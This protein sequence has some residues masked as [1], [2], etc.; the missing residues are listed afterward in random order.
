[1]CN[2][3]K[4]NMSDVAS[5][6]SWRLRQAATSDANGVHGLACEPLVYQYLFD[7]VAP[8][9]K[10]IA[11]W[12]EQSIADVAEV[13]V[14]LWVLESH[15]VGYAGCVQ[16]RPDLSSR[17]AELTYFLDPANRGQGLA[18]RMG[19]TA[20]TQAFLSPKLDFVFAGADLPNI[21]SF[22]VMRR[23]GM[24]FRQHVR[25][26]LGAGVEYVRHRNDTGPMPRPKLLLVC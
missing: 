26:P 19:W 3:R 10:W 23:L 20:V 1:M 6:D 5:Q 14:G 9:R 11:E 12:I 21:A 8:D 15:A 16:L 17:S 22:D 7:G 25:Y 24:R 18:T 2:S 4:R 13:G